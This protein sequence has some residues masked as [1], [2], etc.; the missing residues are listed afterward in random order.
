VKIALIALPGKQQNRLPPLTLAY[1][2][3]ILEQR[4]AIVRLYDRALESAG[5]WNDIRRRLQTFQPQR[6]II[7]G[8]DSR[9]IEQGVTYFHQT[10]P[11]I[12]PL[13]VQR[14]GSEAPTIVNHVMAWLDSDNTDTTTE[15][16]ADA[17]PYPAR[18]LLSLERYALRAPG[19]EVQTPV[20]IGWSDRG[21]WVMRSPHAIGQEIQTVMAE[22]GIRN[23]LFCE[24][25]LTID[26]SWLNDLLDY[27]IK[28]NLNVRW[29]ATV[30]LEHLREETLP[31]LAQAG[32]EALTFSIAA[33]SMFDSV[34]RRHQV[35]KLITSAGELG[36][37]THATVLLE[38]PYEAIARLIDVAATFGLNDVS[39]ELMQTLRVG[40]DE[41]QIQRFARQ[42]YQQGRSRQRLI[43]RFG[44]ALG[45]LLWQLRV[46]HLAEDE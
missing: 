43:D 11:D 17:L 31:R 21:K 25:E 3:A 16:S 18:H 44:P 29:Q 42:R 13:L 30:T 5:S 1:I 6:M 39:F 46:Q 20:V 28:A 10:Y 8:D 14:S 12:L 38:P 26:Q 34:Q 40:D 41:Q 23:V 2:A 19:G 7:A 37:Y 35:Q 24:P 36:I 4:R 45:S 33:S 22:F 32:C 9:I 27:F 15:L